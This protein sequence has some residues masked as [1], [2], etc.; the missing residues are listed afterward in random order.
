MTVLLAMN[1][2][3]LLEGKVP[4]EEKV[5]E[6]AKKVIVKYEGPNDTFDAATDTGVD[7]DL[8][9]FLLD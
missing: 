3:I 5:M 4:L 9:D 1:E 8:N 7:P 6:T 2:R